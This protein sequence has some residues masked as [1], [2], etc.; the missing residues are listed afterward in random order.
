MSPAATRMTVREFLELPDD[1]HRYELIEGE[2]IL[3]A[4]PV[5]RHQRI[6]R[7]LMVRLDRYFEDH[8]GGEVLNAPF[9]VI[10]NEANALQPDLLVVLSSR[11]GILRE[12]TRR[13]RPISPLKSCPRAPGERTRFRNGSCTNASASTNTGS[14]ITSS[15]W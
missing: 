6:V 8:G 10:L 1:G 5:L 14:S 15:S 4:S 2:L 12:R 13:A 11:A 9:D 7:R 3:N